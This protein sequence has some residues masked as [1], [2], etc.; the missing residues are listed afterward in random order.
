M[1][2]LLQTAV[3]FYFWMDFLHMVEESYE[4]QQHSIR[5]N[6]SKTYAGY[7]KMYERILSRIPLSPPPYPL[8]IDKMRAVIIYSKNNLTMATL[9]LLICSFAY[10]FRINNECDLTKQSEFRLF[11][12]A[13]KLDKTLSCPYRKEPI[14]PEILDNLSKIINFNSYQEVR[15]FSMI[16]LMF[17]G[18]LRFREAA[19]LKMKDIIFDENNDITIN[20]IA[21]KT[22]PY[23][24]GAQC[25]VYQ[26]GKNYCAIKWLKQLLSIHTFQQNDNLFYQSNSGFNS[27]FRDFLKRLNNPDIAIDN[28]SAHSMRRGGA[29]TAAKAGIQDNVIQ[30][31]GRWKSSIF[32][33]HTIM[34]RKDA[35]NMITKSI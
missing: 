32:M 10:H 17:Y 20:I 3:S 23:G 8:T 9:R 28:Y 15:L 14:T 18:F 34:E 7:M 13:L 1:K 33:I 16:T 24:K 25:F 4:M 21:S 31:H 11:Y 29:Q 27:K 19:N 6:S 22:D 12:K 2:S 5:P 35:G 26:S 30:R